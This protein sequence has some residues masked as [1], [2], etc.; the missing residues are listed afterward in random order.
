MSSVTRCTWW[1]GD[2]PW[3]IGNGMAASYLLLLECIMIRQHC[4]SCPPDARGGPVGRGPDML[5]V[6][7][8][9]THL[10][11]AGAGN[12]LATLHSTPLH[13]DP[14]QFPSS[15]NIPTTVRV[16]VVRSRAPAG[17]GAGDRQPHDPSVCA[18][19]AVRC[20]FHLAVTCIGSQGKD[21]G[22]RAGSCQGLTVTGPHSHRPRVCVCLLGCCWC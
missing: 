15:A 13:S 21:G 3:Q 9:P 4:C 14:S 8:A 20:A 17:P 16:A 19:P 12:A 18:R 7:N 5:K 1:I 11:R 10:P 6:N 2:G 22:A